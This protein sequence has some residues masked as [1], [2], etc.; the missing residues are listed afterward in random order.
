MFNVGVL[1]YQTYF[2]MTPLTFDGHDG[3][4]V[5]N[6]CITLNLEMTFFDIIIGYFEY[7]KH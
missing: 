1:G 3:A 6:E 4:Y 2:L 7:S 5:L